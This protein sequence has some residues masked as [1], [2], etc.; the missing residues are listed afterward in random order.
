[1]W[2]ET[3]IVEP[4]RESDR[5]DEDENEEKDAGE[6]RRNKRRKDN[7]DYIY[8]YKPEKR[9]PKEFGYGNRFTNAGRARTIVQDGKDGS[10]VS[11]AVY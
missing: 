5:R 9:I 8:E 3:S 6:K 1:M 2:E 11:H 7:D 10:M 4:Y